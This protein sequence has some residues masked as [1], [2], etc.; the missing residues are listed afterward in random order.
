MKVIV[1]E[2]DPF[3]AE[4]IE[5]MI[6]TE[7]PNAEVL[8]IGTE[9]EFYRAYEQFAMHKP[10]LVL[11]DIRVPW[12]SAELSAIDPPDNYNESGGMRRAGLRCCR[13]L[14]SDQRTRDIQVILTSYL[15]D[16]DV[17]HELI[18]L[19]QHVSFVDKT[20]RD[21]FRDRVRS[22]LTETS[23]RQSLKP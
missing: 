23:K 22:A 4:S 3:A 14:L 2:D 11:L 19:P 15:E 6:R 17:R 12:T 10:A 5:R 18:G 1:L 8:I 20:R 9:L 13:L 7:C 21:D 16:R